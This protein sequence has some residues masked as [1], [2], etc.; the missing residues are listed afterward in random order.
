MVMMRWERN[1]RALP[2]RRR[3][4]RP[5]LSMVQREVRTPRSWV[6]LRIP[7]MRSWRGRVRPIV[8]KRVGL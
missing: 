2:T 6:M 8:W 7:D 3:G 4:L 5:S 1:M